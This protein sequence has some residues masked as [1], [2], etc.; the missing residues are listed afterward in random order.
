M[1]RAWAGKARLAVVSNF[2]VADFPDRLL[3]ASGLRDYFEFVIDSSQ[4]GF[5][6]PAP[7]IFGAALE[8][9]GLA[10]ARRAI[11][12]GDDATADMRG[13]RAAGMRPIHYVPDGARSNETER[14]GH[15]DQF[16]PELLDRQ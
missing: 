1:L 16:R 4:V 11:F 5:R 14:L 6:K 3:R 12:I 10:E 15:W 13:A 2:F 9:A 7:E 8:R